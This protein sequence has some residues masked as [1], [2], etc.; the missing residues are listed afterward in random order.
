MPSISTPSLCG[1][2][3]ETPPPQ[4][5]LRPP[6][7]PPPLFPPPRGRA[8]HVSP[9]RCSGAGAAGGCVALRLMGWEEISLTCIYSS[10]CILCIYSPSCALPAKTSSITYLHLCL[11]AFRSVSRSIDLGDLQR[12]SCC[13]EVKKNLCILVLCSFFFFSC[14]SRASFVVDPEQQVINTFRHGR[15]MCRR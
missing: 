2:M 9:R 15:V 7:C 13:T 8:R 6:L 14:T 10:L 11:S 1:V 4:D 12:I 5:C 3:L